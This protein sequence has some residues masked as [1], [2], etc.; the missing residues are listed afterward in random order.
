MVARTSFARSIA[1]LAISAGLA[2]GLAACS[3]EGAGTSCSSAT[4]CTVTF[5]R[6]VADANVNILGVKLTL[7]SADA[8]SVTLNLAG[9]DVTIENQQSASA[10]DLTVKLESITESQIV[11]A[12]STS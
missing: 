5:D 11:V 7:V 6:S 1:A 9:Q 10:G 8:D 12:V 4:Q 3:S 2:A